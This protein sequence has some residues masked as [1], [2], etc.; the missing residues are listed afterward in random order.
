MENNTIKST[1]T[2]K[3]GS[4]KE[5]T[6]ITSHQQISDTIKDHGRE[7]VLQVVETTTFDG[8]VVTITIEKNKIT[9]TI[10]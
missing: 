1:F 8:K 6:V 3:N 2:F 4:T 7:A 10:N 5:G 9:A